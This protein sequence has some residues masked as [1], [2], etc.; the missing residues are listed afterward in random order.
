MSLLGSLTDNDRDGSEN[1][2]ISQD[3]ELLWLLSRPAACL[4]SLLPSQF[5]QFVCLQHI[6]NPQYNGIVVEIFQR[7]YQYQL[8]S[9]TFMT[10]LAN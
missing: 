10:I 6:Y 3:Q 9:V 7:K 4:H 1:V 5:I 2:T 8:E